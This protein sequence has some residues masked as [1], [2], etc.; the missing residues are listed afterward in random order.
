ME[1]TSVALG[2]SE[3][4]TWQSARAVFGRFELYPMFAYFSLGIWE[5]ELDPS[6]F[7]VGNSNLEKLLNHDI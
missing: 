4:R 7:S 1:V 2:L 5:S 6:R 3:V